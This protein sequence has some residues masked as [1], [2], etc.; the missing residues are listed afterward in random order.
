MDFVA[1]TWISSKYNNVIQDIVVC[2][3][4]S[5]LHNELLLPEGQAQAQAAPF[6]IKLEQKSKLLLHFMHTTLPNLLLS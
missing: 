1:G 3:C 4:T 6:C 5:R 2:W